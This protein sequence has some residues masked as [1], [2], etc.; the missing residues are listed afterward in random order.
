MRP[1][2]IK[3]ALLIP[4]LSVVIV[5]VIGGGIGFIFIGLLKVGWGEW[6]AV[7]IGLAL[8]ILVPTIAFAMERMYERGGGG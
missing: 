5:A 4:A 3:L 1:D 8:V 6:G 7:I 2:Q